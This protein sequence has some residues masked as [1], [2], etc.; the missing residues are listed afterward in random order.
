MWPTSMTGTNEPAKSDEGAVDF[1]SVV[2]RQ[3]PAALANAQSSEAGRRGNVVSVSRRWLW[4]V[5]VG[6][7]CGSVS[8]RS[9]VGNVDSRVSD[10]F[11]ADAAMGSSG[12]T[13][14]RWP[15]AIDARAFGTALL[16]EVALTAFSQTSVSGQD[17][18]VLALRPDLVPRAWGAWDREGLRADDYNRAYASSC[19]AA[20][21]SFVGGLSASVIFADQTSVADFADRVGRDARGRPVRHPEVVA[22]AYRGTIAS[23]RFR[24]SIIDVADLQLDA[25]VRGVFFDEVNAGYAGAYSNGNE[26]FDD[27]G[28]ADFGRFLCAKH[29][30]EPAVWQ[31]FGITV[32]DGLDCG[33]AAAGGSF[34][35]RGYL[36]RH[37]AAD[38]PL[39]RANPLR[40]EWGTTVPNRPDPERGTFVE[41]YPSLVY[42][43]EIVVAVRSY[44]R[45]KYG[46]EILVTANG[47]FP[48]V[49]FQS[50]GLYDWNHD[51]NGG[52]EVDYVPVTGSPPDVHYDGRV[53]LGSAFASLRARSDRVQAAV[54]GHPV[55]VL[56]F[57]DWPSK[58]MDRYYSLP[59]AERRDYIR[60]A[61][62]EAYAA[63]GWFA[64]PLSTTTDENTATA[65]G[66]MDFFRSLRAFY[67]QHADLVRG[68]APV[69]ARVKVSAS[70]VSVGAT[71]L[72][73]GRA[74]V[75]L[76]NHD[77]SAGFV[78]RRA[79]TATIPRDH[80]PRAV[81]VASPERVSDAAARFRFAAGEVTVQIEMLTSTA[82]VVIE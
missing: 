28:I 6:V 40:D 46:K 31:A 57:L 11:R 14:A 73:D 41:A 25:G 32:A 38:A 69:Q 56:F 75:H 53:S 39:G 81:T 54:G 63:G 21:I 19:E 48:F 65:L 5:V 60:V 33:D 9:S 67:G 23:P 36:A 72:P 1:F 13:R 20:G 12:A 30:A 68:A 17:P 42:W 22:N 66:M 15:L 16:E 71:A 55:P 80:A 44:A 18:Q 3:A 70:D 58:A 24:Q 76:V 8:R 37:G 64:L 10:P 29:A 59:L 26:G 47:I 43:E 50:V 2:A 61:L 51:G 82:M 35:Y 52:S 27:H 62:A 45:Q 4:V 78:P 49:D 77:Y 7:G 74:V 79:I 34:D